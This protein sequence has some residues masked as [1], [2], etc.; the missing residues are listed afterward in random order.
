M[1]HPKL[2]TITR[3]EFDRRLDAHNERTQLELLQKETEL[4]QFAVSTVPGDEETIHLQ[5]DLRTVCEEG[6]SG[7]SA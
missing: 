3:E 2:D 5:T 6:T 4:A 7:S 1:P